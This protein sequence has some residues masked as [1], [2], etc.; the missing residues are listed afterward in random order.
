MRWSSA[1]RYRTSNAELIYAPFFLVSLAPI[2]AR[3]S[4]GAGG[5]YDA[6]NIST[7]GPRPSKGPSRETPDFLS[8]DTGRWTLHLYRGRS[9]RANA[10]L[11]HGL[12]SSSWMSEPLF[13]QLSD[14]Y[15]LIAPDYQGFGHSDWDKFAYTFDHLA[16]TMNHFAEVWARV[17][18]TDYGGPV[19]FRWPWPIRPNRSAH[20][21]ERRATKVW[22]RLK[23]RRALG[24]SPANESALRA[25]LLSLA[26]TRT[27]HVGATLTSRLRPRTCGPMNL[28]S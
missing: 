20:C 12:P 17:T 18:L 1:Q 13:S 3:F 11:L 15:H 21:S 8:H 22:E 4:Y 5:F 2:L 23:T 16:E 14:R 28:P 26:T 25:N 7:A 19:G 24:R 10:K 6:R 9:G 27:R